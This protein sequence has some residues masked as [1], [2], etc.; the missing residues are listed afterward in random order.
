MLRVT[1]IAAD[2]A[3]LFS[4]YM[5]RQARAM[6]KTQLPVLMLGLL[7]NEQ[8]CGTLTGFLESHSVFRING[9][10]VAPQVRRRGGA[11]L[12]LRALGELLSEEEQVTTLQ[13]DYVEFGDEERSLTALFSAANF[14]QRPPQIPFFGTTLAKLNKSGF[15]NKPEPIDPAA[16][17]FSEMP[18]YLVRSIDNLFAS[19]GSPILDAPLLGSSL[20]R[21]LS[22]GL[23]EG[24]TVPAFIIVTHQLQ[25]LHIALL[26]AEPAY[27][28]RL[29]SVLR[30]AL[31]RANAKCPPET[32]VTMQTVSPK[33]EALARRIMEDSGFRNLARC[34]ELVFENASTYY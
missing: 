28:S 1:S 25:R 13:M 3:P 4:D 20:E 27:S 5:S 18:D 31:S 7:D 8:A 26:Y 14:R 24:R 23:S 15:L 2:N 11:A 6:L 21:E 33:G 34:V 12:L 32:I 22:V 30:A 9:I 29:P 10:Y 16:I 17:P 19:T